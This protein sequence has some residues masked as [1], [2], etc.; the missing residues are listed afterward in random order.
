MYYTENDFRLYHHG[1]PGQKWGR[2]NGPPYP[3]DAKDH[4]AAEK[5]AAKRRKEFIKS[6]ES[7]KSRKKRALKSAKLDARAKK[8]G[9]KADKAFEKGR[10]KREA[11]LRSKQNKI[12][13]ARKVSMKNLTSNELKV[14]QRF[15]EE[16]RSEMAAVRTAIIFGQKTGVGPLGAYFGA[17]AVNSHSKEGLET[18]DLDK[19]NR[20][21]YR[22]LVEYEANA[23]ERNYQKTKNLKPLASYDDETVR[24]LEDKKVEENRREDR[25]NREFDRLIGEDDDWDWE[26]ERRKK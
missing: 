1:I 14:G 3:L 17:K 26:K 6:Q 8:I 9:E 24:K 11:K 2:K 5:E 21:D 19:Q 22:E 4:S 23:N 18:R 12:E 25:I 7:F 13:E 10:L 15:F 16:H 20:K